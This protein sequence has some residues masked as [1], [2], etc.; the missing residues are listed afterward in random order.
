MNPAISEQYGIAGSA[1]DAWEQNGGGTFT[2][3][4]D[5]SG[6]QQCMA[7]VSK[8]DIACLACDLIAREGSQRHLQLQRQGNAFKISWSMST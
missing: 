2:F 1:E 4:I 6:E 3:K 7:G 8:R 5:K